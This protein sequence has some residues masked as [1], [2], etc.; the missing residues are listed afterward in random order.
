MDSAAVSSTLMIEGFLDGRVTTLLVDTGSA[1]TLVREDVWRDAKSGS[2]VQLESPVHT[3]VAANG[4]KLNITGQCTIKIAVGPLSKDH[5]VLVAKNL[6]QECLL[7]ADFLMRHGCVLDLQQNI[8]FTKDGPVHLV[9]S[10][11]SAHSTPVCFVTLIETVTVPPNCQMCLPVKK[12]RHKSA[13][14]AEVLVVEPCEEFVHMYGLLVAHSITDAVA[15]QKMV[16]VM[17]PCFAP[18]TV[19]ADVRVGV[20]QPVVDCA[21]IQN[22][23][24]SRPKQA[25]KDTID[26]MTTG[27][28]PSVK[29][30]VAALLWRFEDVIALNDNDLGRTPLV[31]HRIDMADARPVR[32]L[33]RRLPF[34][35]HEE[36]RGLVDNML[37]QGIIEPC[38]GPWASPILL[39]KKKD[40]STRFCVDFRRVNDMTRKDAQPLPRIDDTLDALGGACYFS[41]LD[42]ASGYWQVEVDSRDREK[43]GFV[44]P[45]GLY[46][47]R[48]MPFGLC[49]APAT[50][51]RLMEHVLAGLHWTTCLVYLDDIIIF[52]KSIEQHIAQLSDVFARLKGAGL[53]IRPSKCRLLQSSVQYLG[54]IISGKG[55]KTDPAKIACVAN[56]P[57]PETTAELKRFLG[58]AS[59]YRRFV[60]NFA[61]VTC[62]L[63]ALTQKGTQWLWSEGCNNAFFELKKRLVSSPILALPDFSLDFVLDTDASGD[64]LGAVLSQVSNGEER[65]LAYASRALSRTERKYCATRR[66]MLALVWAARHFRPY[67]YGKKFTLRTDHH[68]LKWLHNFKEPEGQVARWLEVLSEFD[69]TVVHRAGK[70]HT[71]ADALSRGRC[72]QCGRDE[73]VM[74]DDPMTCDAVSHLILPAWTGDEIKA[75][76]SSDLDLQQ[77]VTWLETNTCPDH[78]P[79]DVSWRLSSLWVQRRYLVLIDGVLHRRWEDVPGGGVCKHLQLVLPGNLVKSVLEGLHSTLVGG[80]MGAA[81]TLAKVRARFYWPG[82]KRDVEMWCKGCATCNSR[83]APP[84]R[85]R[86]PLET[87]IVQRPLQ[88]V[89]MDILGPLPETP[90]GNR[91]ILVIGDYFTKWKEAFP[92]RDTE[93]VTVA[94]VFVNEFICR[95]GVPDSL[96]TDQGK[97]FEAKIIKEIC[98]L[99][100]I[101]KTRTTAYHP[102][103]DGL[104]ERFNRTLLGML[105]MMVKE[106]EQGW[107]LLLPTM[108]LAYRTSHHATTGVTPFELM[109]GRNPRLPEDV[110]FS[111][112]GAVEDP[113]QYA[114][115]LKR[116]MQQASERVLQY[117]ELQQQRQK[118]NYDDGVRGKAYAVND[119][120]FLHNP[121]VK[122]GRSKKFHKPWQGPFRVVE[123][124]GPSV[125]RIA[126]GDNPRKQ[127][128]VHFNRLKPA[129]APAPAKATP[130][131]EVVILVPGQLAEPEGLPDGARELDGL[132]GHPP[133]LAPPNQAARDYNRDIPPPHAQ[134][135]PED[136]Q[137][138]NIP[139]GPR[140]SARLR[141]P[142]VRYGDPVEIP[143][144]VTDEDLFESEDTVS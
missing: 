112:P 60:R 102:Q 70:R 23:V 57:V 25:I 16:Q 104:V 89:A 11:S 79:N 50:F 51:Q 38:C 114:E 81:K 95:F 121:A 31:S 19:H 54:H 3:V 109:F 32:Q 138:V 69:Y 129:P 88:R 55:I 117:M 130:S 56:W 124:L 59:Y 71:N 12:T 78:L 29:D 45:C 128:V 110:L 66:E 80:H 101:K 99:L 133:N 137:P 9:S 127:K 4:G 120:V 40:G 37:S 94:R 140:R 52:S 28:A 8:M 87:S 64:G 6:H 77:M 24:S 26:Q 107:D 122:R 20:L 41:T 61:Q 105:S 48:V 65:V 43:T 144:T 34:H 143:E 73:E 97:N 108:L 44:T 2:A 136:I 85:A 13:P 27:L 92:L 115:I 14:S 49:N 135:E 134:V 126:D 33:A 17:N 90:R 103:S 5:V 22:S 86:A 83:K 111:I 113:S 47:F 98:A 118:E 67:L 1:V 125:Y 131:P 72:R 39:A 91:Y 84:G 75:Q 76:Q 62:P 82:Q 132:E 30:R 68:S 58:F 7:G 46:Q 96:H 18:I 53:K 141:R 74:E 116:R 139:P 15:D 123:V 100:D 42:L 93:A 142:V 10:V 106:D 36:V 21:Q 63:N 119:F 35:L